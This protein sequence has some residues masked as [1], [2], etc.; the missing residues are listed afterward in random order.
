MRQ[1]KFYMPLMHHDMRALRATATAHAPDLHSYISGMQ[2]PAATPGPTPGSAARGFTAK[3]GD[4]VCLRCEHEVR[5]H[6]GQEPP[7][8]HRG[9]VL[10]VCFHPVEHDLTFT[11]GED[12]TVKVWLF[13][14]RKGPGAGAAGGGAGGARLS[15]LTLSER[16]VRGL[17]AGAGRLQG[18]VRRLPVMKEWKIARLR[19]MIE[20]RLEEEGE[21]AWQEVLAVLEAMSVGD[22]DACSESGDLEPIFGRIRGDSASAAGVALEDPTSA[23]SVDCKTVDGQ[24]VAGGG[25]E[26]VE[27]GAGE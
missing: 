19:P 5:G 14:A 23:I 9:L 21:A 15:Q 16:L 4:A 26:H 1:A 13:A 27:E 18:F 6:R 2:R 3:H 24:D 22:I 11:C 7:Q 10:H 17:D 20:G 8:R 25:C 12:G